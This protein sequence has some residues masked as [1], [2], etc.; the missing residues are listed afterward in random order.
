[1]NEELNN[2]LPV[3]NN[4]TEEVYNAY[5]TGSE[6]TDIV[7]PD[8]LMPEP[9]PEQKVEEVKDT[10]DV[11]FNFAFI[12][13]GQGGCR[14]AETFH[15]LGYRK[16]A[17]LNTAIQDLNTIKEIN[18]KLCIGDGGAGKNPAVAEKLYS[19]RKEDVLD[20]MKAS[21]GDGL[22]RIFVCAGAGG[23]TGAGTV[24]PLVHAAKELQETVKADSKKV[25]V[26]LALPKASEGR[27]VNAN[28]HGTLKKVY[29]LVD[30]G[31]VSPLIILDN[32]KITKLYPNLVVSN[33]W[34]TANMSTAGL[35]NLFN[36]TASKDSSYS[37]FDKRDYETILNSGCIVFGASP[38]TK[39]EDPI[40]ISR[41][42]RENLS[43][44]LLSGGL[45]LSTGKS[46]A[47]IV[48]GGKEQL[49]NIP[50]INLDQA[51]DQLSRMLKPG[52]VVHRGI[53][54]G[55]K[56]NLT[57]FTAVGGISEPVEKLEELKKLG[58]IKDT[59]D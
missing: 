22:D 43:N 9:E 18:N 45:D 2:D 37:A 7:M 58:D 49:D 54:V 4:S 47:A 23:G 32:E 48:I 31:I 46:A 33:F 40:S 8:I 35:F 10:I 3:E 42:V 19:Q 44:N 12:G 11:A 30:E 38:V 17:A 15:K 16:T 53:Y 39:W 29:E 20:F 41:A 21:F 6:G 13:A 34:Q 57:I 28:A 24:V 27:R 5:G 1:M 59:E 50:Q 55:D 52:N 51:F 56:P 36:L 26:I 25:G 14:I